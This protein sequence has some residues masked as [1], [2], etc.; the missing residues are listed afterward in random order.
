MIGFLCEKSSAAEN[1]AKAF[2]GMKG[3]YQGCD[4]EI[5]VASGHLLGFEMPSE[6][7]AKA[8]SARYASWDVATLPWDE[9]DFLWKKKVISPQAKSTLARIGS[10]LSRCDEVIIATDD[11]PSGEGSLLAWEIIDYLKLRP[12]KMTRMYFDDEGILSLQKAFASRVSLTKMEEDP[13]YKKAFYR[14]AFDLLS[15]QFTRIAKA[16]GDG[17]SVLR[18]GR[19]KSLMVFL[20]GEALAK[21]KAYKKIPSYQNRFRDENQNLFTSKKEPIFPKKE[22]VPN[23][24]KPS[25]VVIDSKKM[26]SKPPAPLLDLA[27]ISGKLATMGYSADE[28]LKTYQAMYHA[29]IVS[30][31]RTLDR[32]I[33]PGQFDE[34]LPFADS[35]AKLVGVD[36]SLLTHKKPRSTHIQMNCD[37]GANRPGISVPRSLASLSSFGPSAPIIYELVAKS[38]LSMLAGDYLYEQQ[39]GHLVDYPDFIGR[40]NV[41]KDLGYRQ[42]CKSTKDEEDEVGFGLG[43]LANPIVHE[44]FPPRPPVPTMLWLMEQLDRYDVGTGS[45]RASTYGVL[46]KPKG[47]GNEYPLMI[48]TKGK[49]TLTNYG[50][51]SYYL[52]QGTNIASAALTEK[53]Q[54][55]MN[56]IAKG[57]L[58]AMERLHQMQQYVMEDLEI[59]K[60]NGEAYRKEFSISMSE[61]Q[62]VKEK[63]NGMWNG[64]A[65]SFT[66][67]WGGHRFTDAECEALCDGKEIELLDTVNGKGEAMPVKGNLSIQTYKGHNFVGFNRTGFLT[68]GN[69]NQKDQAD[70]YTGVWKKKEVA[71]KRVFRGYRFSDEECEALCEDKEIRIFGLVSAKNPSKTYGVYGKLNNL[72]YNGHPYVGFEQLGFAQEDGIP[73]SWCGHDF[74]EDEK[75]LLYAGEQLHLDGCVSQKGNLFSPTVFYGSREDGSKGIVIVN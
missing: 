49:I 45:T 16:Y 48:D 15:M 4:Y 57:N 54:A 3:T 17:A 14:S 74:T 2:G 64:K 5:A 56:D 63:Y 65:V 69:E 42:I 20:V 27:T 37:H 10:V 61:N 11:D 51:M 13:D 34:L 26:L 35:I 24:Y 47:K 7:V 30:Y 60:K 8:L 66:R 1:F 28:V 6:Q 67:S 36:P 46:T 9:R 68:S 73:E 75:E 59:M 21:L 32:F 44:M 19:L 23:S 62:N 71:F 43:Q 31:P 38:Y 33:T 40:C 29:Q 53:V 58:N 25:A 70:R 41:T 55:D 12:K 39:I 22:L 52:I 72:V 50:E 18:Q